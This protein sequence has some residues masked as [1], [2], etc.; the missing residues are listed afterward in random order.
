MIADIQFIS[1][2]GERPLNEDALIVSEKNGIY[3]VVDGATSLVPFTDNEGKTGG[4]IAAHTIR[5]HF[6][7]LP[8][9]AD[10]RA[11]L[12]VANRRLREE[13]EKHGI[14]VARKERLWGAAA[15]IVSIDRHTV[16]YAQAGDCMILAV[17]ADGS[18]R[19]LT[20]PQLTHVDAR[21]IAKWEEGRARGL[22]ATE[23]LRAYVYETLK[24]N[25][26]LSNTPDGYGVINGE[27]EAEHYIEYG[28]INK[29]RLKHLIL[30]SDGFYVPGRG[31]DADDVW[32]K[33]AEAIL[34]FGLGEYAAMLER[35]EAEDPDGRRH[36]R[37][38]KSDDKTGIVITLQPAGTAV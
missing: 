24:A 21:T 16:R 31:P 7:S 18:V 19:P 10:V 38:K 6:E 27:P 23:E 26:Q 33:L 20:R 35:F 30:L 36:A 5:Q 8:G 37:L 2:R 4:Y 3:G 29:I 17:Y 15:A 25:R 11:E 14:D 12:L 9:P 1:V 22:T 34:T 28:A 13:M 32:R